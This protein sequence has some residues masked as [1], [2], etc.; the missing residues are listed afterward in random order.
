MKRPPKVRRCRGV[1]SQAF[2][3]CPLRGVRGS[4]CRCLRLIAAVRMCLISKA[5]NFFVVVFVLFFCRHTNKNSPRSPAPLLGSSSRLTCVITEDGLS[6][7]S[8]SAHTL[9]NFHT[10]PN[11]QE[12]GGTGDGKHRN[13]SGAYNASIYARPVPLY[14]RPVPSLRAPGAVFTRRTLTPLSQTN[15]CPGAGL[16]FDSIW[17]SAQ[18]A[19]T[20]VSRLPRFT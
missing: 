8:R 11:M 15:I 1:I 2:A 4:N 16:N 12:E 18:D 5:A 17:C 7:T 19:N 20:E 6:I 9:E 13:K 14:A 3:N 10:Q